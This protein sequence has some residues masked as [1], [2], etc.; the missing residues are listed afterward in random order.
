MDSAEYRKFDAVGLA[1][2][3][4]SA[5][6][7]PGELLDAALAA[8][9]DARHLN[10][11]VDVFDDLG[12]RAIAD[13]LPDGPLKGVPF[14]LKDLWTR[15]AGTVTSNSC[16]LF[17]GD[18]AVEDSEI[19]A[20]FRRAG[21]VL[22]AK[23]NSAE[24]GLSPT[25]EPALFGV[26][27]NPWSTAHSPGGSSGGAAAAVA[28]GI[29]PVAHATD[30]GGSIRIPASCCGVFGLK[31]TRG[32]VPFGPERGEGWGGMSAQHV[33]S[34]SVRDSAVVLD[35]IAGEMAGDPYAAPPSPG[36][37]LVESGL[38][39]H[40]LRIGLCLTAPGGEPVDPECAAATTATAQRCEVLGHRVTDFEWPFDPGIYSRA[41][42]TLVAPY[43]ALAVDSR[44]EV[45]G[46]HLQAGDL[47]PLSAMIC[48]TGR[49]R[50]AIEYVSGVQAMHEVGRRLGQ[51]LEQ[52]DVL[53]TPTMAGPP[54]PLGS[55]AGS[56]GRVF[57]AMQSATAFTVVANITGQPA[58][59]I[60]LDHSAAGLPVG[61]Q[62]IGRFGDEATL[63][64]LAGQ[65]ER[66]HPWPLHAAMPSR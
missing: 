24:L 26:T 11:I 6:V 5:K 17:S 59:S 28:G 44:L 62:F 65:L 43:V 15:M 14:A 58:M 49:Q 21:L 64:R 40:G 4:A 13:G 52:V 47:E 27:A 60:P 36:S 48:D 35:S 20:R 54:L 50:S 46:R 7:H 37:Y 8:L 51:A 56:D 32:R 42:F 23:T 61:S 31:P 34:R 33:V 9:E 63:F 57:Q 1:G 66:A 16:R 39:P 38:D 29:L 10:A 2:L 19:V 25:T 53:L 22:F 3:V 18:M 12:R 30:G 45:L 55:F 41:R